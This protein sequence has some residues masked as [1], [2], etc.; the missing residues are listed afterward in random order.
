M[1]LQP[2]VEA[3]RYKLEG[4][5]LMWSLGGFQ[6]TLS[7]QELYGPWDD[8]ASN[9]NE[10]QESSWGVKRCR[11]IKLTSQPSVSP[12]SRKC[13]IPDVS[14]TCR[15]PRP[16][17]RIEAAPLP[18]SKLTTAVGPATCCN[19]WFLQTQGPT[20]V[21]RCL[22]KAVRCYNCFFCSAMA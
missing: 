17:T 13:W 14:Q 22:R 15:P 10:Y 2:L 7:S 20:L 19:R 9:R 4:R 18:G 5:I 12:L 11:S 1:L 6:L 3:L 16:V 21:C 8:S